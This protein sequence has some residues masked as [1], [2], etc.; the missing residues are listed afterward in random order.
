MNRWK[1]FRTNVWFVVTTFAANLNF[2]R[3]VNKLLISN[4]SH[5]IRATLFLLDLIVINGDYFFFF[6]FSF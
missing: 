3:D 5:Y 4:R 6:S 2:A 1:L